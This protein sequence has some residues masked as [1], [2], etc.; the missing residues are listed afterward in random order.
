MS[1]NVTHWLCHNTLLGGLRGFFWVVLGPWHTFL[2]FMVFR[3]ACRSDWK[4]IF[5]NRKL[6]LELEVAS[7]CFFMP[8]WVFCRPVELVTGPASPWRVLPGLPIRHSGTTEASRQA[9]PIWGYS[10]QWVMTHS[11]WNAGGKM[12]EISLG[13]S[14]DNSALIMFFWGGLQLV[15]NLDLAMCIKGNKFGHD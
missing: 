12:L 9:H 4:P 5:S 1:C 7:R 10:P 6:H 15:C 3:V 2:A 8:F 13:D 11:L 14:L